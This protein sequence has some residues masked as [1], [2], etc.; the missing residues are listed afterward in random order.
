MHITLDDRGTSLQD[1]YIG[2]DRNLGPKV[3]RCVE[4]PKW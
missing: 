2:K 3:Y 1:L 4:Y